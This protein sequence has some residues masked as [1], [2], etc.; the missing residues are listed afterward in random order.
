MPSLDI[1]RATERDLPAAAALARHLVLQHHEKDPSR[2][3]LPENVEEGYAWWFRRELA[4]QAAVLLVAER[5]RELV[6]YAYGTLEER[7][8][9]LLIDR[10]GAIHDILVATEARRLG[11][12]KALLSGVIEALEA[13]GAP[14]ILLYTMVDNLAAQALFRSFGFRPTMLEMTRDSRAPTTATS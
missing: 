13:L 12:G 9:N 14:R 3:F 6:G 11:T 10:H 5:D 7:N 2:F 1:R 4:R 8:F